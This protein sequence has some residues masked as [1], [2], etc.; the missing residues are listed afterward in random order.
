MSP[1][2]KVIDLLLRLPTPL[3]QP[4]GPDYVAPIAKMVPNPLGA[5]AHFSPTRQVPL[6]IFFTG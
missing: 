5:Q 6:E 2:F 4:R 1:P 3:R